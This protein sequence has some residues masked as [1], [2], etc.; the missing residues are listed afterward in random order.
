MIQAKEISILKISDIKLNPKNRNKHPL[1]Q[2]D[3]LVEVI[4]YQGFRRPVTVSNRTGLLTCGEGRFLAAKRLKMTHIPV[5]FQ[6]YETEAQEYA[7]AI[8]DNALDKWSSLDLAQIGLDIT[9]FGPDF[10]LKVLGLKDFNLDF[11]PGTIEEQGKLDE[12]KKHICP[13]CGHEF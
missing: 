10:D 3:R 5:M 2:I 7:D 12:K 4:R 8:A 11:E 13:E 6:D 9:D 1:D